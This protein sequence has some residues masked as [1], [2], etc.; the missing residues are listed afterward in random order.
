MKNFVE[1]IA[2]LVMGIGLVFNFI[3]FRRAPKRSE[4]ATIGLTLN[5]VAAVGL[6]I[7]IAMNIAG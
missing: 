1:V 3:S 5:I 6:C 2:I 7:V 4:D